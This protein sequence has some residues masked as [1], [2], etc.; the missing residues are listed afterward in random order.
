[1]VMESHVQKNTHTCL[2]TLCPG[3]PRW[4]GTKKVKPIWI[5]L[6]QET[7]SS[8][9]ISWTICM[10]APR[11]RQITTPAP[12]HSDFLQ[13]GC[14]SCRPTNSVKAVNVQKKYMKKTDRKPIT[15]THVEYVCMCWVQWSS[16]SPMKGNSEQSIGVQ[17]RK[18]LKTS[19][20]EED[21]PVINIQFLKI[22]LQLVKCKIVFLPGVIIITIQ[23]KSNPLKWLAL[24]PDYEYPL[25]HSI[26]LSM[27]YTLYCV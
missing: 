13:A 7:V 3:L 22:H 4:T 5:L 25:R 6:K 16:Q 10:S 12:H 23:S 15:Q 27:F 19:N 9:G 21:I 20:L 2:T 24:G 14:P 26:H 8:S 17:I 1:M 18:M 11:S